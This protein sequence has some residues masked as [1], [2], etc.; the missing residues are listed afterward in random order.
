MKL[1]TVLLIV[2]VHLVSVFSF[3]HADD[4]SRYNI[5][6]FT[7]GVTADSLDVEL[8]PMREGEKI[9]GYR[10]VQNGVELY[11]TPVDKKLYRIFFQEEFDK[12]SDFNG[13]IAQTKQK[14]GDPHGAGLCGR[15]GYHK[16]YTP[17]GKLVLDILEN[18]MTLELIDEEIYFSNP[19]GENKAVST[20]LDQ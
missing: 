3:L 18:S 13:I 14:Y 2:T 8:W 10:A 7:T 11:F 16:W 19:S 5:M 12:L 15:H 1:K 9:S 17:R 4:A 20:V 6:G